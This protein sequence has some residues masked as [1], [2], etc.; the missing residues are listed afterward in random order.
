MVG[1]PRSIVLSVRYLLGVI[2]SLF[3]K[4]FSLLLFVAT[5]LMLGA[6]IWYGELKYAFISLV[7]FIFSVMA[8]GY[9]DMLKKQDDESTLF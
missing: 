8:G 3:M 4:W 7:A 5:P 2:M 1:F 6:S 9:S